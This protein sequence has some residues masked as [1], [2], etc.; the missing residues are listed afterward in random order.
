MAVIKNFEYKMCPM[1]KGKGFNK[2]NILRDCYLCFG[3]GRIKIT[4]KEKRNDN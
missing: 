3:S 2:P 1:C 4:L